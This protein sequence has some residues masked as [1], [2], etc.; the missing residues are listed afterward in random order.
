MKNIRYVYNTDPIY[1]FIRISPVRKE[2]RKYVRMVWGEGAKY[3]TLDC[4]NGYVIYQEP[5]YEVRLK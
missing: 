3:S 4:V 1:S 5:E 2:E